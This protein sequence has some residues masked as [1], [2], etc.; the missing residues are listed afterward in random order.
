MT[1]SYLATIPSPTQGVWHIGPLPLRAYAICILL[2]IVAACAI[3]E[4]R[5]R[6]RGAP[7]WLTL[8]VAI[9]AVPFGIVGAR[10]YHVITSPD[11]YFGTGGNPMGVFYVWRGGLGIWG[12]VA[13]GALGAWL[14]C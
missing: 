6:R 5:L 2:G 12:A 10:I 13:G 14:A 4:V 9:F 1:V 8:D 11:A 3:T 7:H